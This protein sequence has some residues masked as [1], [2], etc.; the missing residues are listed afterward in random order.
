M[1]LLSETELAFADVETTGLST[2]A[3]DR[4]VE[5]AI[6]KAMGSTETVRY[7][8]LVNPGRSIPTEVQRIHGISDADVA[9][10]PSF[11]DIAATVADL[12]GG[13]WIVGHHVSFDVDF[14]GTELSRSCLFVELAGMFDTRRLA[15]S[16]WNLSDNSL[17]SVARA[18]G[19]GIVQQHRA[20]DDTKAAQ[21]VFAHVVAELGGWGKV[22]VEDLLSIQGKEAGVRNVEKG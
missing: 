13:A 15:K 12:L 19:V 14:I 11:A 5:V 7:H 3:G 16:T 8:Q 18:L 2:D 22:C 17:G 1:R 10:C 20:L 4:I 6:I 21:A 9:D